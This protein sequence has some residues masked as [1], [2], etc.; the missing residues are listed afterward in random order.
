MSTFQSLLIGMSDHELTFVAAHPLPARP[1]DTLP[2]DVVTLG[3]ILTGTPVDTVWSVR[4]RGAHWKGATEYHGGQKTLVTCIWLKYCW[5]SI[6]HH[7]IKQSS[8]E[9]NEDDMQCLQTK[10]CKKAYKIR[11][12]T[13]ASFVCV[14]CTIVFLPWSHTVPLK[15]SL[16]LQEPS[17]GSHRAP[18]SHLHCSRHW[19]P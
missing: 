17:I 18:F 13:G 7:T 11:T 5:Y 10:M 2:R 8:R 12:R 3:S 6:K 4:T 1:T 19:K 15:P 14:S 16:H 9:A